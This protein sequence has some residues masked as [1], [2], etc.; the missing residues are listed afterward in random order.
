MKHTLFGALQQE[1]Q[2]DSD[3]FPSSRYHLSKPH[4]NNQPGILATKNPLP[5]SLLLRVVPP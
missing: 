4:D 5:N 1:K 3:G 2:Q